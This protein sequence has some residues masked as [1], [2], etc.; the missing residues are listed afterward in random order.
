MNLN[1]RS[2]LVRCW[3]LLWILAPTLAA[4]APPYR[5]FPP[6]WQAVLDRFSQTQAVPGAVVILKSPEW[7]VR[8][9]VTG[10]A[11]LATREKMAPGLPFRIGSV[12]KVFTAQMVL[13][14]EQQGRLKLTDPVLL[15]LGDNPAVA[16][17][18][19]IAKVTLADCLQMKSGI[20]AYTLHPSISS[21]ADVDPG[22]ALTATELLRLLDPALPG[23]LK[24][25]FAP[26]DTYPNPYWVAFQGPTTPAPPEFPPYPWWTYS[27]SNYT[28]LGLV[29]EKV[30]G[31]PVA[32]AVQ[33]LICRP[34]G[35]RDTHFA[36]D[37]HLPPNM[38]RGYSKLDAT[39][40][41]KYSQW[42]DVTDINPTVAGAA[43][44]GISTPWDL[45]RFL[46]TITGT[47]QLLNAGTQRK[48]LTFVSADIHWAD[49]E[50][51]MG[52][53]MQLQRSYG[54]CRGHGGAINGFKT[55]LYTFR[56]SATTLVIAANTWDGQA[57]VDIM[58]AVMPLV[59]GAPTEP[60]ALP[61]RAGAPGV[62]LAWQPGSVYGATYR[63]FWG[64]R[65]G[66][67]ETATA[68][69]HPGVELRTTA[70]PRA[71]L[72]SLE[73]GKKYFWRVETVPATG[74]PLT[75]PVWRFQ[76]AARAR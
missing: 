42:K 20:A 67:V 39:R 73:P 19:N 38:M 58:D 69:A 59:T 36:V 64:P 68:A 4:A 52:G 47:H 10:V 44:A 55:I 7:G 49:V 32:E 62:A 46:E 13:L 75:G 56:D 21:K 18:P 48:W 23:A 51:G 26:G 37:L 30:T 61:A 12:S 65:P 60:R 50:Y 1:Q 2:P 22:R 71:A 3:A 31:L 27:N 33:K 28:L 74:A 8:V 70:D 43:G 54:D 25:D 11:N 53:I 17:I 76:T 35:L 24:P 63:V 57:E 5:P 41:P 34:L 40:T 72:T 14:L 45:L 29:V 15:H 9:G 16:A 66:L 6:A